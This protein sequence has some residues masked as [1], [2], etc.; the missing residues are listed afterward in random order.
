MP[1]SLPPSNRGTVRKKKSSPGTCH[2]EIVRLSVSCTK[3]E[4]EINAT[5]PNLLAAMTMIKFVWEFAELIE[6]SSEK[7]AF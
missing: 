4:Y 2:S 1:T 7:R 3:G 5:L 6:R